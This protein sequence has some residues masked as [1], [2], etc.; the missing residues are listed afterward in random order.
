MKKIGLLFSILL[1]IL[2]FYKFRD[3][4]LLPFEKPYLGPHVFLDP[5]SS[6]ALM[7]S[8]AQRT[9]LESLSLNKIADRMNQVWFQWSRPAEGY[10]SQSQ[11]FQILLDGF[12]QHFGDFNFKA[13]VW[14]RFERFW[15]RKY[16]ECEELTPKS[17]VTVYSVQEEPRAVLNLIL[18]G[19]TTSF[20]S[21]NQDECALSLGKK[22]EEELAKIHLGVSDALKEQIRK[23]CEATLK[24][25]VL[26]YPK[27]GVFPIQLLVSDLTMRVHYTDVREHSLEKEQK[28]QMGIRTQIIEGIVFQLEKK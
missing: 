4:P 17:N 21:Q 10:L 26:G 18:F 12:P 25:I 11:Y 2:R 8:I 23:D 9:Q 5:T 7:D 16:M 3:P 22:I 6:Q 15:S 13:S 27:S 24:G 28:I 1:L 14:D 19:D 20:A